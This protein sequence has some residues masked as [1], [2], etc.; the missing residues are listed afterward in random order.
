LE[1]YKRHRPAR[2]KDLVGQPAVV[3]A[4]VEFDRRGALPQ[5]LLLSGPSGTGKTSTAWMLRKR[6]KCDDL[7]FRQYDIGDVGG[8]EAA[9]TITQTAMLHPLGGKTKF[10]LLDEIQAATRQFFQAMLLTLEQMPPWCYFVLCT[11][12]PQKLPTAV[13]TRCTELRFRLLDPQE[14]EQLVRRI[15]QQEEDLDISDLVSD[16]LV[17]KAEGSP[18]RLLVLLNGLVGIQDEDQ[19]LEILE[20][21]R[22]D[23]SV[24]ANDLAKKLIFGRDFSQVLPILK[25][26]KGEPDSIRRT[27]LNYAGKA[28]LDGKRSQE[29]YRVIQAFRDNF[30]DSGRE[31]LLAACYEVFQ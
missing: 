31:G 8:I 2:L 3:K 19:Q 25:Q 4:L 26:L 1:L 5:A 27:V 28:L 16:R 10:F 17:Q 14:A 12:D 21:S 11:T 29:A 23:D 20:A 18:R 30:Q 7:D 6:M 24:E 9:R 22:S 13:R 15:V